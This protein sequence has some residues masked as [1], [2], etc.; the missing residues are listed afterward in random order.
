[1]FSSLAY[2]G[3]RSPAVAQWPTFASEVLGCMVTEPGPDGAVRLRIDD[4]HWRIQIHP[5]EVDETAYFGWAVE[6]EEDLD[7][8]LTKLAEAGVHGERGTPELAAER[9]VNRIISFDDPWGFRH[10]VI[11]GQHF[12]PSSFR[13]GRAISG[14]RTGIQG[15]GHVVLLLPDIEKGH[16]FFSGVLGFTL[17]DKIISTPFNTRFY[18]CNGRHHTL[19]FAEYDGLEKDQVAFNHLMLELESIDDVGKAYDHC[20]EKGVPLVSTIGRHTNDRMTSFYLSSPSQFQIE[21]GWGGVDVDEEWVPKVYTTGSTWGHKMP[22]GAR[23]LP[24]GIVRAF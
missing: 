8:V 6:R 19:A 13:P 24:V 7:A 5:G 11:W 3:V 2:V 22:P 1:M 20:V 10:E 23:D 14:F 15:L 9:S 18:H 17:S 21:Y 12:T 16:E 4:A